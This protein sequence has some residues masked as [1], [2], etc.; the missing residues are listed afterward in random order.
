M[1]LKVLIFLFYMWQCRENVLLVIWSYKNIHYCEIY[2]IYT[3]TFLFSY[4][5][6]SQTSHKHCAFSSQQVNEAL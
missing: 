2:K 6:H 4:S 1:Y 3:F 5:F